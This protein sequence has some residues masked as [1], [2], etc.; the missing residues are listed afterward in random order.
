MAENRNAKF[1]HAMIAALVP[2]Q[3]PTIGPE[4]EQDKCAEMNTPGLDG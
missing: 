2:L 4:M 3:I 1:E